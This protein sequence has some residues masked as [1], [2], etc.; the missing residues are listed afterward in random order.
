LL[1]GRAA[2]QR[3]IDE[4]L[5]SARTGSSQTLVLVGDPGIG[6]TALLEYAA[7]E[8]PDFDVVRARGVESE[9]EVPFAALYELCRPFLDRLDLLALPQASALRAAFGL[10]EDETS[11][12]AVGAGTLSL[13]AAAAEERPLLLL[14]DDAHWLDR[15][16]ADA[17]AF[18]V[19]RLRVDRIAAFLATR[20]GEGRTF[21]RRDLPE[22][23]LEGLDESSSSALLASTA[24]GVITPEREREIIGLARGNPLALLELPKRVETAQSR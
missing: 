24:Q 22:L 9:A 19:R 15:S 16:S 13:L 11:R 8:A 21:E 3:R 10:G 23:E 4:L 14:V 6:K 12:F 18:A 17:L 20:P 2:A 5:E 1:I 7:A